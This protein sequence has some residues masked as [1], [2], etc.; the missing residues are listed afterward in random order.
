MFFVRGGPTLHSG[1]RP[2]VVVH[3]GASFE[4]RTNNDIAAA[5]M[6]IEVT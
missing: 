4:V 3:G 2:K 6:S 5:N 1:V